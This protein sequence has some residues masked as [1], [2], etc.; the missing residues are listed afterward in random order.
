MEENKDRRTFISFE[1]PRPLTSEEMESIRIK[2]EEIVGK[3]KKVDY[4]TDRQ[5]IEK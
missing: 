5:R 4:P 2:V 1:A 3:V